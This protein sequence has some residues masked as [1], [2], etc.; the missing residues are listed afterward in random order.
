MIENGEVRPRCL[1]GRQKFRMPLFS[2]SYENLFSAQG[3]FNSLKTTI[4]F[5]IGFKRFLERRTREKWSLL[6]MGGSKSL[7]D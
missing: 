4:F 5:S 3:N 1:R 6:F 7:G 2:L